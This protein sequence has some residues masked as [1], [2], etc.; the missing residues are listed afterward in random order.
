MDKENANMY[1]KDK[2]CYLFIYSMEYYSAKKIDTICRDESQ[3][4]YFEQKK[5]EIKEY[6]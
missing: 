3:K 2:K 6:I 5:Q 1:Q 4:F